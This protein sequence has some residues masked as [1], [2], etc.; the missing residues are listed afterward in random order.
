MGLCWFRLSMVMVGSGLLALLAQPKCETLA[1]IMAYQKLD[2]LCFTR[3]IQQ[4][5][6]EKK[7]TY[8]VLSFLLFFHQEASKDRELKAT[9]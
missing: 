4:E 7:G 3:A 2:S 5:A 8:R 1:L 6:T 9:N